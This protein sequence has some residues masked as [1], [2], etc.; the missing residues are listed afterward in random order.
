MSLTGKIAKLGGQEER[1]PARKL[2]HYRA[3][4]EDI[5]DRHGRSPLS[6]QLRRQLARWA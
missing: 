4:L 1:P 6:E 2:E 5:E 3:T